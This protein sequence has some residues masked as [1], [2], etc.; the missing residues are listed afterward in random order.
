MSEENDNRKP[1]AER[2][3][4]PVSL[5]GQCN[6]RQLLDELLRRNTE[7]LGANPYWTRHKTLEN[8]LFDAGK[9]IAEWDGRGEPC[10]GRCGEEGCN[11][12]TEGNP[13]A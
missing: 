3:L 12:D 11:L 10:G 2:R 6:D 13:L 7:R 9:I 8:L 5:L 4:A 1:E